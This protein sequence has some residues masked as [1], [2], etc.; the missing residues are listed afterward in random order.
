MLLKIMGQGFLSSLLQR[1]LAHLQPLSH[2]NFTLHSPP[3]ITEDDRRNIH[4]ARE[5]EE[6]SVA[7][8]DNDEKFTVPVHS[9]KHDMCSALNRCN[10]NH[11]PSRR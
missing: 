7:E 4:A 5:I 11:V 6:E 2:H 9:L 3:S 10:D 1:V 8:T